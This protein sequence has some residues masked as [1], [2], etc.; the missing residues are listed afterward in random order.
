MAGVEKV[1]P[2]EVK[3]EA[4]GDTA[5]GCGSA[6]GRI[7]KERRATARCSR[8]NAKWGTQQRHCCKAQQ[9]RL[10]I[11]SAPL[12]PL[13]VSHHHSRS[14]PELSVAEALWSVLKVA[15]HAIQPYCSRHFHPSR[16]FWFEHASFHVPTESG[17][18][19]DSDGGAVR[20]DC[21]SDNGVCVL[22]EEC[23][24][25]REGGIVVSIR[26][27]KIYREKSRIP[28]ASTE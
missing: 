5:A 10:C 14:S 3:G 13:R 2:G 22:E 20:G 7:T 15:H 21:E 23:S 19:G 28:T 25:P 1:S 27:H 8:E 4:T 24:L 16:L 18:S 9:G 6:Q 12:L 11:P 26:R 17:G